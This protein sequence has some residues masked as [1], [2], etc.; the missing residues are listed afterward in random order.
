MRV[1]IT[2]G[3]G[4]VGRNVLE[5]PAAANFEITAPSRKELDLSDRLSVFSYFEEVKPDIVV[6][7]A[8]LVGGIQ[9]NMAEPVKFLTDNMTIGINVVLAARSANVRK[10][11]NIGSSCMYP[12]NAVNPLSEDSIL[13]GELEFTNE[14]YA[15]SKIACA[16]LCDYIRREDPEYDYKTIIPSNLYGRHDKFDPSKSHMIPAV[17]RKIDE[18]I[19]ASVE[20]VEIWGSGEVRREFMYAGDLA[21]FLFFAIDRYEKIPSYL[22]V[23]TGFDLSINDY[24]KAIAAVL[25]YK[26]K[27]KHN[28]DRPVGME[29]KLVDVNRLR[30]LDWSP[31]TSLSDGIAMTYNFYKTEKNR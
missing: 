5:H 6:H 17:I 7:A 31:G 18:A 30:H 16:R 25:G 3:S 14:G 2:G 9:A 1:L 13:T 27:F 21:A 11:F 15:I 12:R 20:E 4:M 22:N 29:Q 28:L 10:L 26:G 24:Y 23:G 8:G 19:C